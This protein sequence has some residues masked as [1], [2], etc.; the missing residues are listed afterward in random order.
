MAAVQRGRPRVGDTAELSRTVGP[1]DIELFTRISGDRDPLHYD[2][3]I[4]HLATCWTMDL[5]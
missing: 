5:A 4:T 3:P 2:E 1:D